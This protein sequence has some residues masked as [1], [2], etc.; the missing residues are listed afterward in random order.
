MGWEDEVAVDRLIVEANSLVT[1]GGKVFLKAAQTAVDAAEGLDP[2]NGLMEFKAN[3]LLQ[4]AHLFEGNY[5][6]SFALSMRA[7]ALS[8]DPELNLG[9]HK[10][11]LVL[12]YAICA[13]SAIELPSV[14]SEALKISTKGIQRCKEI[15]GKHLLYMQHEHSKLLL[16]NGLYDEAATYAEQLVAEMR[17]AGDDHGSCDLDCYQKVYAEALGYASSPQVGIAYLNQALAENPHSWKLWYARAELHFRAGDYHASQSDSHAA[18]Q[19]EENEDILLLYA[20]AH[21]MTGRNKKAIKKLLKR[22]TDEPTSAT[23]ALWYCLFSSDMER[24]HRFDDGDGWSS[25]IIRFIQ[26]EMTFDAL[27]KRADAEDNPGMSIGKAYYFAGLQSAQ[28]GEQKQARQYYKQCLK[29][30]HV[31]SDIYMWV[32]A[33][34]RLSGGMRK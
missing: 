6:R 8:E 25:Q 30:S 18:M 7:I 22:C 3:F 1:D 27:L 15:G 2:A 20:F 17:L 11:C 9:P 24:L 4:S 34:E 19:V 21:L 14:Q 29:Y 28:Q 23:R 26:G 33:Q 32:Y 16:H 5:S 31:I 12:T 10:G 13:I